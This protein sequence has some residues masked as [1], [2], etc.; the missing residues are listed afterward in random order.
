MKKSYK[1]LQTSEKKSTDLLRR[2]ITKSDKLVQK[3][4]KLVQKIH[5]LAEKIRKVKT[6]VKKSQKLTS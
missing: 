6:S 4:D 5:R 3:S 2:K 1:N